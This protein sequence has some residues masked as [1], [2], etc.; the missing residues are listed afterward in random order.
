MEFTQ[1]TKYFS[2]SYCREAKVKLFR[3]YEST[4]T[5]RQSLLLKSGTESDQP[6][7]KES[8]FATRL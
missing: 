7:A 3:H 2:Y 6:F 1:N 8:N 5:S 4:Y